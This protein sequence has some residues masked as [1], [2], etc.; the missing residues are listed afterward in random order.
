[1]ICKRRRIVVRRRI[2]KSLTRYRMPSRNR[3]RVVLLSA[4]EPAVGG[5]MSL[6]EWV[7]QLPE[8]EIIAAVQPLAVHRPRTKEAG[9]GA[10]ASLADT[11]AAHYSQADGFVVLHG[12][13]HLLYT[14]A[15]LSFSLTGLSKPVVVTGIPAP[16]AVPL[17][18]SIGV[19]ANLINAV[20][21][22]T[23]AI[24]EVVLI[25]GNRILRGNAAVRVGTPSAIAFDAPSSAVLGRIDFS[26]RLVERNLRPTGKTRLTVAP[27]SDRVTY[28]VV[29]PW[30]ESVSL[31]QAAAEARALLVDARQC[32][33]LPAWLPRLLDSGRIKT[34]VA[35]LTAHPDTGIEHPA[36]AVLPVGTPEAMLAKLAWAAALAKIPA[37]VAAL[38]A[39]N[40][41]GEFS[42]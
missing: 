32:G 33:Q 31:R 23:L 35:V 13:D 14:A 6:P 22:A 4:A 3:K 18:V 25:F 12:F 11:I 26:I 8:L 36:V 2:V 39:Q 5:G 19:K 24:P 20:Q 28:L 21:A 16:S 17:P 30:L 9:V 15:A 38:M 37:K 41:A 29:T 34:P 27:L 10:V 42:L 40:V 7:K 1:M